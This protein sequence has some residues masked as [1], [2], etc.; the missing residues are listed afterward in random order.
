MGACSSKQSSSSNREEP[1]SRNK[2]TH[3]INHE[4]S[5]TQKYKLLEILGSGGFGQVWKA[6]LKGSPK[7][8]RAVKIIIKSKTNNEEISR[9]K[10][11]VKIMSKIDHP[12]VVSFY[13][14]FEDSS[15]L[16]IV[17]E[18]C[19]GGELFDKIIEKTTFSEKEAKNIIKQMLG[20]I[21]FCHQHG[22]IHRDIKPENI[23]FASKTSDVVKVIDFGCSVEFN[24]DDIQDEKIG[25][26]YYIAPEI[27]KGHYDKKCDLWSIGVILYILLTGYP[28]FNGEG[29]KKILD[30]VSKGV[31]KTNRK[32][33]K[34][35]SKNAKDLISKLLTFDHKKRITSTEAL[36]H[37]WFKS[38]EK[39]EA[40]NLDPETLRSFTQFETKN[41]LER[42]IYF[43]MAHNLATEEEKKK[44]NETFKAMD[45][46]GD[47]VLSKQEIKDGTFGINFSL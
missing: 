44:L 33:L 13:E 4:G 45:K 46:N 14:Y 47:G 43:F 15:K 7:T 38:D 35:V 40:T 30:K 10:E 19:D 1:I 5:V 9:I 27:L 26:P 12:N 36:E 18:I 23:V 39:D 6:H 3:I 28:P 42:A 22:I 31:Y 32:E 29:N 2:T 21:K 17:S 41:K 20:A 24:K 37:Q 16:Y 8:L 34:K 25:T 11:E